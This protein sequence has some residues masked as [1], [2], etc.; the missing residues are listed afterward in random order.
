MPSGIEPRSEIIFLAK[1]V[2][3]TEDKADIK[4]N[5]MKA[6]VEQALKAINTSLKRERRVEARVIMHR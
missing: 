1:E 4:L 3:Y 5:E 2:L 6:L